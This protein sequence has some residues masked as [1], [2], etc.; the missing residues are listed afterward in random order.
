M[1]YLITGMHATTKKVVNMTSKVAIVE[2]DPDP[3][4]SLKQALHLIGGIDDLNTKDRQVVIKV[5]VFD[6]RSS[7]H[8]T[9]DVADAI[10]NSFDRAPKIFLAESDNYRGTADERLQI[11]KTLFSNRVTPFNLSEDTNTKKVKIVDEQIDLS[12]ILFKPNVFVSTHILRTYN[13]GSIIKNLFGT[14][15]DRKK[16][17][18]HKKGVENVVLDIY[19]AIAGID[20]AVL[21]GSHTSLGAAPRSKKAQTNILVVGRDAIAVETVGYT[22]LGVNPEKIPLIQE[23][24]KRGIGEVDITK[25]QV[26]GCSIEEAKAR[27]IPLLKEAKKKPRKR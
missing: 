1:Q 11:W 14:T 16:A 12:H 4:Q 24:K 20:L 17:R 26:V 13:K 9:V 23:A 22:I 21:D 2:I 25:I 7:Q 18:F 15:P 5:G 10:I 27:I 8:T 6:H 19:Q 3:Y